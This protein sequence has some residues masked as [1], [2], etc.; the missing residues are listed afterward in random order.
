LRDIAAQG[1]GAR[2]LCRPRPTDAQLTEAYAEASACVVPSLYEGF[3]LPVLEAMAC[4]T[5]VIASR[6]GSL[7]EVGGDAVLYA[8]PEASALAA[9]M[10]RILQEPALAGELRRAGYARAGQFSWAQTA[11]DTE[12]V[13]RRLTT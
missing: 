3:G 1:L 9:A 4:G 12:L 6:A 5:P 11:R 7:A 10:L 2:V 8:E 13:Y